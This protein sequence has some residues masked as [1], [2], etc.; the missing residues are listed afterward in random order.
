MG[1]RS[2]G[3]T[4]IFWRVSASVLALA[5]G[6]CAVDRISSPSSL[7]DGQKVSLQG[8]ATLVLATARGI[9]R[10]DVGRWTAAGAIRQGVAASDGSHPLMD[11]SQVGGDNDLDAAA[12][13]AAASLVRVLGVRDDVRRSEPGRVLV[14]NW[15]HDGADLTAGMLI[16]RSGLPETIV[17][18]RDDVPVTLFRYTFAR[19]RGGWRATSAANVAFDNERPTI[20]LVA[21][22]DQS[23]TAAASAGAELLQLAA[24]SASAVRQSVIWK[25]MA[26]AM[27]PPLY[28]EED[29]PCWKQYAAYSLASAGLL[30]AVGGVTLTCSTLTPACILT[31]AAYFKAV[32]LWTDAMDALYKCHGYN[33]GEGAGGGSGSYVY[34]TVPDRGS[35]EQRLRDLEAQSQDMAT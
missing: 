11:A 28:A 14:R 18:F 10:R 29:I 9:E 4:A 12:R 32:E 2:F 13:R 15:K 17:L 20:A 19:E 30:T 8:T 3:A 23:T 1:I 31:I 34:W 16:G 33:I 26:D 27:V 6:A 24:T 7:G 25:R 35:M 5:A 22:V 21:R